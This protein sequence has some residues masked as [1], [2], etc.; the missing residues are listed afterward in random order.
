MSIF[1]LT[2]IEPCGTFS[3]VE[4]RSMNTTS[5]TE[6]TKHKA[7]TLLVT[8]QEQEAAQRLTEAKNDLVSIGAAL[9]RARE[10]IKL[11]QQQEAELEA[12]WAEAHKRE[13]E[14]W[15]AQRSILQTLAPVRQWVAA[16]RRKTS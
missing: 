4:G 12:M 11:A 16:R 9:Q 10:R 5:I 3:N 15:V 2:A 6:T 1:V 14:A 13:A 8:E 7:L